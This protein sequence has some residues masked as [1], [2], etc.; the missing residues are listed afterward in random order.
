MNNNVSGKHTVFRHRHGWRRG[1]LNNR[2]WNLLLG[3]CTLT[4]ISIVTVSF[5][6][7]SSAKKEKSITTLLT[8]GW[9]LGPWYSILQAAEG[10]QV[11]PSGPYTR[12]WEK[13]N[14]TADS[15]SLRIC[16]YKGTEQSVCGPEDSIQTKKGLKYF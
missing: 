6:H 15:A 16:K 2:L 8:G 9:T 7:R 4:A 12:P 3:F 10:Q 1:S 5:N 13:G 11:S 14:D